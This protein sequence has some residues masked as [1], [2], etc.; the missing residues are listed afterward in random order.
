MV[1]RPRAPLMS[2]ISKGRNIT[3]K[4]TRYAESLNPPRFKDTAVGSIM[5]RK[6]AAT[7]MG[8]PKAV[9][10][11]VLVA[12]MAQVKTRRGCSIGCSTKRQLAN[13]TG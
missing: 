7:A 10:V 12:V 4:T 6:K 11:C 13:A 1:I 8:T 2:C 5:A 9:R 3:I